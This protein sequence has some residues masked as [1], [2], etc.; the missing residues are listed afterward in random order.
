MGY[1]Q[2]IGLVI[3]V[4]AVIGCNDNDDNDK[5]NS[6]PVSEAL[7]QKVSPAEMQGLWRS[8][9]YMTLLE[10]TGGRVLEYEVS[11]VHC[12]LVDDTVLADYTEKTPHFLT[13]GQRTRFA[14][15]PVFDRGVDRIATHPYFY[16]RIVQRPTACVDGITE[17]TDDPVANFDVFWNI[18]NEQ[19]AFFDLRNIYWQQKYHQNI[20][21]AEKATSD[22]ELF[23]IF[24]PMI[25]A[26][27][28]DDH[29]SLYAG[30]DTGAGA[31]VDSELVV[32]MQEKFAE[33]FAEQQ[34]LDAFNNQTLY[35]DFD[36][37]V[38]ERFD[39]FLD[40]R[41]QESFDIIVGYMVDGELK[42]AANDEIMWGLMEDNIGYLAINDMEEFIEDLDSALAA[43]EDGTLDEYCA[44]DHCPVPGSR[45]YRQPTRCGAGGRIAG[46]ITT[47]Y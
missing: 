6:P 41:F 34:L 17:E 33:A 35:E 38:E 46:S 45:L 28:N 42:S 2:K 5:K 32:R 36:D 26:F 15:D 1:I 20:A 25:A 21:A 11:S 19:Y 24:E 14:T 13:N 44:S 27:G 39:L 31:G 37:Y 22:E 23:N 8:D 18:A 10:I 9:G 47:L 30:D 12:L 40:E 29:V 16:N 4:F 43:V 3:A 7:E